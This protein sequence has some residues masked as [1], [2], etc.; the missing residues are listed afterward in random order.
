MIL[1][2]GSSDNVWDTDILAAQRYYSTHG[3]YLIILCSLAIILLFDFE[4]EYLHYQ[5]FTSNKT[6]PQADA[7]CL[8]MLNLV[9]CETTSVDTYQNNNN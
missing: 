8:Q 5:S 4:S 3:I 7:S 1:M 6:I 9:Q 2:K